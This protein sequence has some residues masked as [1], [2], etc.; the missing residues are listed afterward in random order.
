MGFMKNKIGFLIA[1]VILLSGAA[2]NAA[3]LNNAIVDFA[4]N[5]VTVTGEAGAD[6]ANRFVS[7]Q[8]VNPGKDF[9]NLFTE[10]GVL[11]RSEQS[12]S[13]DNGKFEFTFTMNGESGDY[14]YFAGVDGLEQTLDCP[15]PFRY[16]NPK[17]V[18]DIWKETEKAINTNN[19]DS[20]KE[21]IDRYASVLQID[22]TEYNSF[23]DD[24]ARQNVR[25]G[26]FRN[27]VGDIDEFAAVFSDAVFA[28]NLHYETDDAVFDTKISAVFEKAEKKIKALYDSI[29]P[30]EQNRIKKGVKSSEFYN[31]KDILNIFKEKVRLYTLNSK[32]IWTEIDDFIINE[33]CFT[34]EEILSYTKSGNKQ[35]TAVKILKKLPYASIDLFLSDLRNSASENGGGKSG[36]SASGAADKRPL[37]NYNAS[38]N[39]AITSD[40]TDLEGYDWALADIHKLSKAGIIN[41]F[42][43]K[44]YPGSSVTRAEFLKMALLSAK[45]SIIDGNEGQFEDVNGSEWYAPY[46]LTAAAADIVSGVGNGLF[47]P[48]GS[49]TRQDIAVI[50]YN[51]LDRAEKLKGNEVS[52]PSD[53]DSIS[54]YA[55]ESVCSLMKLGVITGFED[56][57]FRGNTTAT[58]AEA[59]VLIGRFLNLID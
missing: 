41:G 10:D 22:T 19:D 36:A 28:V 23:P 34:S 18:E 46:V 30:D 25:K 7:L 55:K 53:V 24:S 56:G 43:G 57:T 58:R 42:E 15:A 39:P 52:L 5:T 27:G 50:L 13:D 2:A 38:V 49:I 35:S 29:P 26:I 33:G 1:A 12:F 6:Y 16:Y 14:H 11:N 51:L 40:F 59:A 47:R 45:I 54:D 31:T 48:D 4:R 3:F 21:I 9:A 17:Y 8:L 44:F 20:L 32:V 37:V